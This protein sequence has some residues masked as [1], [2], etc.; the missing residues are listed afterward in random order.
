MEEYLKKIRIFFALKTIMGCFFLIQK[1][2]LQP[3]VNRQHKNDT[4]NYMWE[5]ASPVYFKA[6][7]I[8]CLANS[9]NQNPMQHKAENPKP[10]I[11]FL[12]TDG[13]STFVWKNVHLFL[14]FTLLLRALNSLLIQLP[15]LLLG[16]AL[17]WMEFY[18]R[19]FFFFFYLTF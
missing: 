7:I 6:L 4:V 3:V 15:L 19:V 18:S 1:L 11:L 17:F 12:L 5:L 2:N 10:H 9:S 14:L 8:K 13:N 16:L